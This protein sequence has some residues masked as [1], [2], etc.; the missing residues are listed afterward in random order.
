MVVAET[1]MYVAIACAER[2]KVEDRVIKFTNYSPA[3]IHGEVRTPASACPATNNIE[4]VI[5]NDFANVPEVKSVAFEHEDGDLVVRLAVDRPN[6][7]ARYK[8]YDKQASLIEAFPHY[9][10][11]FILVHAE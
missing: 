11:N 3:L 1:V 8:I 9:D 7:D 4:E 2:R 5:R 10:L 6:R